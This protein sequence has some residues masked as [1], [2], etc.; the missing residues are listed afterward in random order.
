MIDAD[1]HI[2]S[3][4]SAGCS[5]SMNLSTIAREAKKKGIDLVG[6]GDCLHPKWRREIKSE[7][8]K[9]DGL[10]HKKYDIHFILTAEI[11]DMHRVHHL[12][13]FPSM[14]SVEEFYERVKRYSKDID[15][16]GR[17]HFVIDA[18]ELADNIVEVGAIFGPCHA[19]T[20]WTSL[21]KEFD[22][23][24]ECYKERTK[25]VS[26][27]E[28]GL[29]ADSDMADRIK[30]LREIPFLS[31]SDAHSPWPS[32]LAREFNRIATNSFDFDEIKNAIKK[33]KIVLNVGLDPRLGKYHLS[34][35]VRCKKRYSLYEAKKKRW[36]CQCGGTI[37]KGVFDRVLELSEGEPIHSERRAEYLRIAPL[38]EII[39]L[40]MNIK[41]VNSKR[42]EREWYNL[43]KRFGDE[44]E[45]LVDAPVMEIEKVSGKDIARAIDAFR[46]GNFTVHP[47][48]GGEYGK[49]V[50]FKRST[51]EKTL[52]EYG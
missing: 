5:E 35:C 3:K 6:T 12:I 1:F 44:I 28:L 42:V 10:K 15:R 22:S 46:T 52:L 29:S 36:R 19:F 45:V 39:S 16:D 24:R 21:Y 47:G 30:E 27:L 26:F 43:V 9:N 11:E 34:A 50:L 20:P 48:G 25:D 17:A 31:N 37:K 4:Y 41:T 7:T 33:F 51:A 18:C 2:H 23:L 8:V 40:A 13:I 49:I 14:S 32:R 38:S